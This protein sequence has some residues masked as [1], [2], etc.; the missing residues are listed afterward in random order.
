MHCPVSGTFY[1]SRKQCLKKERNRCALRSR[2][3]WIA[4]S[5]RSC[6]RGSQRPLPRSRC[7]EVPPHPSA[8]GLSH[9]K[10]TASASLHVPQLHTLARGG[11]LRGQS[12]GATALLRTLPW[13]PSAFKIKPQ[14]L[15]VVTM[16][17]QG[18]ATWPA[19]PFPPA[20]YGSP[21][22]TCKTTHISLQLIQFFSPG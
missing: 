9:S 4:W 18:A 5:S 14:L 20:P 16:Y 13:L 22:S 19:L 21:R 10:K 6:P 15:S 11:A 17:L 1:F 3:D 8:V 7:R 12:D 2:K